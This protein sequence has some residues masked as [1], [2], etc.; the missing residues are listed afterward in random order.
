MV[1][2]DT[3]ELLRSEQEALSDVRRSLYSKKRELCRLC[4][5][6][7][8]LG[9][10]AMAKAQEEYDELLLLLH[11]QREERDLL[12]VEEQCQWLLDEES[13]IRYLEH[14]QQQV[15]ERQDELSNV[16]A[17]EHETLERQKGTSRRGTGSSNSSGG[18]SSRGEAGHPS[19]ESVEG[20]YADP[21]L[22]QGAPPPSVEMLVPRPRTRSPMQA[23]GGRE[24]DFGI[25]GRG[26]A[27]TDAGGR[28][29][30]DRSGADA[31]VLARA[32]AMVEERKAYA[33]GRS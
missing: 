22:Q 18:G 28:D 33:A 16:M 30:R 11:D 31:G 15:T 25:G 19:V 12:K 21:R 6:E 8:G 32:R 24:R 20:A 13:V 9:S 2:G 5:D 4:R 1:S 23:A 3:Q 29:A 27:P 26:T 14:V 7:E 17:L 10:G